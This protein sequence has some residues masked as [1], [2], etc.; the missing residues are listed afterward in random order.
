M[1]TK[2]PTIDAQIRWLSGL[3]LG[4]NSAGAERAGQVIASLCELQQHREATAQ[5]RTCIAC[6]LTVV[7]EDAS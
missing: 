7:V 6:G 3:S 2:A 5:R 4:L 1:S